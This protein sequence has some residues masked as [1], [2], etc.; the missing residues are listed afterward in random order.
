MDDSS[1]YKFSFEDEIDTTFRVILIGDTAVGKTSLLNQLVN[2]SFDNCE[3]STIGAMF[4]LHVEHVNDRKI[5]MQIWD[6]AG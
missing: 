3:P 5:E 6:T 2:Q 4:L 1:D